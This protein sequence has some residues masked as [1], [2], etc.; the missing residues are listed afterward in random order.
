MFDLHS[1]SRVSTVSTASSS[2]LAEMLLLI[3]TSTVG[4]PPGFPDT[5]RPFCSTPA[6][7]YVEVLEIWLV[8]LCLEKCDTEKAQISGLSQT[9]NNL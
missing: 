3:C 8:P 4:I 7:T 9:K 1:A 6:V 2:P 5:H